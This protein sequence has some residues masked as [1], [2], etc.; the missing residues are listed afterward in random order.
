MIPFEYIEKLLMRS[1]YTGE[2]ESV[3]MNRLVEMERKWNDDINEF[4][5]IELEGIIQRLNE[6][7][8]DPITHGRGYQ[9]TDILK[10][11]KKLK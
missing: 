11:L 5:L 1:N 2:E 7:Q 10:H 8:L 4:Y 6:N 9:A 3:I